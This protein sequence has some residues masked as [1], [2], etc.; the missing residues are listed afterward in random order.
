MYYWYCIKIGENEEEGQK[1]TNIFSPPR[2]NPPPN[3]V[4]ISKK[5]TRPSN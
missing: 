4:T 2:Y 1:S 5:L 3:E